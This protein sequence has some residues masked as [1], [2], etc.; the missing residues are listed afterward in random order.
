MVAWYNRDDAELGYYMNLYSSPDEISRHGIKVFDRLKENA[1]QLVAGMRG[2][3]LPG[4]LTNQTLNTLSAIVLNSMFKRDGRVAFAEGQWTCFGTMDQMWLAR[5]VMYQLVPEYAWRELEYWASTQMNNG[6][7]HHDFNIMDVGDDKARRYYL[8]DKNDT[9]HA[10]YRNIQK[11]VDLNCAMIISAYEAW[12]TTGDKSRLNG[13]WPNV[14]RAA[15][16][17]LDQTELYGDKKYP[18]TF[19]G[20]ENSYD[21]GG[22]PDPYN[23]T[24]SVVAYKLMSMLAAEQGEE[25]LAETYRQAYSNA[26]NAFHNRYIRDKEPFMGKHCES[27]SAGQ[28][29]ALDL[30]IGEIMDSSD[31]EFILEKLD[32]FYYPYYWGLGY[33]QGT[34]DEWTPYIIAHYGGLMLNTGQ[35]DRWYVMQKDAY[36]RQYMNRD[37]V[38]AHPLNILPVVDRPKHV[39]DSHRSKM[40]YISIPAIWRNYHDIVGFHHDVSSGDVWLTPITCPELGDSLRRGYFFTPYTMGTVDCSDSESDKGTVRLIN[41]KCDSTINIKSLHLRN[42]F[43]GDVAITVNGIARSYTTSGTGFARELIVELE[44]KPYDTISVEITGK[45]LSYKTTTPA[46]PEKALKAAYEPNALS[47]YTCIPTNKADKLAGIEIVGIDKESS[48]ATSCNN[49]DYMLFSNLDFTKPG[50]SEITLDVCN[51][52]EMTSEVEVVMDDTSGPVIGTCKIPPTRDKWVS[53]S[54]PIKKTRG[55]HNIILRFFGS[56][57]DNLMNLKSISFK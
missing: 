56:H 5:Q 44:D 40:Q 53:L 46:R 1:E 17:I 28:A 16:R 24:L 33:P 8:V 22:N 10:D 13:L 11:W 52:T 25:K 12:Q 39:S 30:H 48:Y 38:F 3:N 9:E 55:I 34:Y 20:S 57:P 41:M 51:P 4:W 18:Y 36:M 50:A 15:Q 47:P 45:R 54:F 21:A 43:D 32:N 27:V 42:D 37:K 26:R 19:E 31:T 7:I 14:K 29:L 2:S 49:F 23:S 35:T 6:Q